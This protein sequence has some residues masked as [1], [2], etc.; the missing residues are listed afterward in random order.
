M[1]FRLQ[2]RTQNR[3]V[4]IELEI[5]TKESAVDILKRV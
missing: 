4:R 1:S 5:K 3:I 2:L